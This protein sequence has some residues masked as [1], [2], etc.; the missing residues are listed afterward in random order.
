MKKILRKIALF[1]VPSI[2]E[3][4]EEQK[5]EMISY[6]ATIE[7]LRRENKNLQNEWYDLDAKY[8]SLL[9]ENKD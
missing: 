5:W 6:Q 1:L 7:N 9:D 2:A 4:L 8:R 3:Q